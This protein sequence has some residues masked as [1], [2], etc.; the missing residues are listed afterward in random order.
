MGLPKYWVNTAT[1][2]LV[3]ED[4]VFAYEGAGPIMSFGHTYNADPFNSGI[5]GNGWSFSYDENINI[6][7]EYPMIFGPGAWSATSVKSVAIVNRGAGQGVRFSIP[8]SDST[9]PGDP[10]VF[11]P[12]GVHFDK[13]SKE[14]DGH[15]IYE[16]QRSHSQYRFDSVLAPRFHLTKITDAN[17]NEVLIERNADATINSVTDAAGR[18]T[19]FSYASF[20]GQQRCVLMTTPDGRTASYSYDSSGN[21]IQSIDLLG[22]VTTYTY[23]ND[24]FVTSLSVGTATTHF[25]YVG[26]SISKR[27][28]SITDAEGYT[29]SY[30][31]VGSSP[32]TTVTDEQGGTFTYKTNS[33]PKGTNSVTD[34]MGYVTTTTYGPVAPIEITD[35]WGYRTYKKYDA[36]GNMT[37]LQRPHNHISTYS[38]DTDDNLLSSTD[39]FGNT[40]S[41]Q[42]DANHNLTKRTSP[43]GKETDMTYTARGELASLTDPGG[44]VTGFSYDSYGNILTATDALLNV[45]TFQYDASGFNLLAETD[46]QGRMSSYTYD[47]NHRLTK[48]LYDD[49]SSIHYGYDGLALTS[50]S[51]EA[52]VTFQTQSDKLLATTKVFDGLGNYTGLEHDHAGNLVTHRDPLGNTSSYTYDKNGSQTL[53]YNPMLFEKSWTYDYRGLPMSFTDERKNTSTFLYDGNHLLAEALDPYHNGARFIYDQAGRLSSKFSGRSNTTQTYTDDGQLDQIFH[54]GSLAGTFAY[55]A[56]GNMTGFSDWA[57]TTVFSYNALKQTT[58]VRYP[59]TLEVSFSLFPDGLPE[60][61]HYPESFDVSYTYDKR[62]R[63]TGISWAGGNITM[64]YDIT[65]RV[66]GI[67]RSNG[68]NSSYLYDLN[69]RIVNISHKKQSTSFASMAYNRDAAGNITQALLNLPEDITVERSSIESTFNAANQLATFNGGT[70]SYDIDGNLTRITG[71]RDFAASYDAENRLSELTIAAS[72]SSFSYNLAGQ[73]VKVVKNSTTRNLHPDHRNRVLFETNADETIT[74][75]YIYGGSRPMVMLRDGKS[76]FYHYDQQSNVVALT[77][78]T[79]T[80]TAAYMYS[81]FGALLGRSGNIENPFTWNG[82]IGV[83]DDGDGIYH[84]TNRHYDAMS[85][86]FL[87][88]DPSGFMDGHNLYTYVGNNPINLV[89]PLGLNWKGSAFAIGNMTIGFTLYMVKAAAVISAPTWGGVAICGIGAVMGATRIISVIDNV[90]NYQNPDYGFA[91]GAADL[92]DPTSIMRNTTRTATD[93]WLDAPVNDT[94]YGNMKSSTYDISFPEFSLD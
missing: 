7:D 12:E 19:S 84:M 82:G 69:G 43:M 48:I 71:E 87:Q 39:A 61:I 91:D 24:N 4:V 3:I 34:P 83:M 40:W 10:V 37:R 56:V 52:G 63:V 17:G 92:I 27:I 13:L 45:T 78:S 30:T 44:N 5:F 49:N 32:V 21:L 93:W 35:P 36:R 18:T 68:T 9:A 38:Y 29:I 65:G 62:Q 58:A 46:P 81:P 50:R 31:K 64:S 51:D 33:T 75:T 86:R 14:P 90:E 59:D 20:G 2:N 41:Y 70:A 15:W 25:S 6:F 1:L 23:D 54:D 74:T 53:E 8:S 57:G 76:Y 47:N 89:D 66:T 22:T 67:D 16:P 26:D 55:D 72:S 77:D 42:Y 60:V 94:D 79:G 85:G 88:K 80:I 28:S 73:R 11:N